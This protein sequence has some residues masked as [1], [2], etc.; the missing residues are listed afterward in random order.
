ME[1]KSSKMVL[2]D[3]IQAKKAG[4]KRIASLKT[5]RKEQQVA[6][7]CALEK[8]VVKTCVC[9]KMSVLMIWVSKLILFA[10]LGANSSISTRLSYVFLKPL[11]ILL[12][13]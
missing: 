11:Y 5:R 7:V 1:K 10:E 9:V 12:K 6:V 8:Y 3:A 13:Y 2:V 4:Q